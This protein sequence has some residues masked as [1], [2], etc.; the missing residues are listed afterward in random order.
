MSW[1][2][3]VCSGGRTEGKLGCC[4]VETSLVCDGGDR[5]WFNGYGGGE[6]VDLDGCLSFWWLLAGS[7]MEVVRK[8]A[9]A[10]GRGDNDGE[11]VPVLRGRMI[12]YGC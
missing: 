12:G 5:S 9:G 7:K 11:L 6:T 1:N 4:W 3:C 2:C 10:V 8:K